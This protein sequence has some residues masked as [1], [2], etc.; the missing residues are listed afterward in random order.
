LVPILAVGLPQVTEFDQPVDKRFWQ[1][2]GDSTRSSRRLRRDGCMRRTP[3][4]I[5]VDTAAC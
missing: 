2:E 4:G 1:I 5:I 3:A